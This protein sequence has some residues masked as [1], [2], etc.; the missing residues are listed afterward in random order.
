MKATWLAL[1]ALAGV[2]GSPR[3]AAVE[4]RT[5][6]FRDK[7]VEVPPGTR[8]V[9]TNQDQIEH[10]I[11]SGAPDSTDGVFNAKLAGPGASFSFTF[12]KAGTYRYFCDRHHFMRGEIRVTPT[13]E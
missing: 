1:A 3:D 11:T 13:G 7:A 6:Q 8:V 12:T 2:I 9:W 10:T 4:V 5:F